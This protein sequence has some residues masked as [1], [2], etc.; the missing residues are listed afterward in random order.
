MTVSTAKVSTLCTSSEL[1]LVMSSR[2][3]EL[4]QL[5]QFELKRLAIR[6]RNLC[7]KSLDQGR[8]QARAKSRRMGSGSVA[9]RTLLKK[10]IFADALK[11][12]EARL[13]KLEAAAAPA[14]ARPRPKTKKI[15]NAS[16][17]ATRAKVR[18]GLAAH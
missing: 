10:Q 13:A 14:A 2:P 15:R 7:D 8:S 18:K 4:S 17:R 5:S 9:E 16:H 3:P 12:F 11:S 6:A 1:A